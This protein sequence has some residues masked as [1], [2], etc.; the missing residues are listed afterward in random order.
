MK[1]SL[2]AWAACGEVESET[3][4]HWEADGESMCKRVGR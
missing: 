2:L 3:I 4:D 1:E